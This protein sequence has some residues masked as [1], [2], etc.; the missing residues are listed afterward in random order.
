MRRQRRLATMNI[1]VVQHEMDRLSCWVL[2]RQFADYSRKL[3]SGTIRRRQG[4]MATGLR[5][6]RAENI[7]RATP[8][9]FAILS[10]LPPRLGRRPR[11]DISMQRNGLLIHAHH[12]FF[13]VVGLFV[14]P[15][16][17]FHFGDVL[18][19]EFWY[20]PHFFPATA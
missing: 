14:R 11:A 7:G 1:E 2:Q 6:Y 9:V 3:K 8:F 16:N 15:Q 13:G 5:L 18:F 10:C 12:W 19:I 17:V 4:E 20:G